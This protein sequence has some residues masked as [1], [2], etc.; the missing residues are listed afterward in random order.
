MRYELLASYKLY[1][2]SMSY[3][4]LCGSDRPGRLRKSITKVNYSDR[5]L[6][7]YYYYHGLYISAPEI[8]KAFTAVTKVTIAATRDKQIKASTIANS[9]LST[10]VSSWMNLRSIFSFLPIFPLKADVKKKCISK[11]RSSHKTN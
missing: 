8:N 5:F 4:E 9:A 3:L 1:E 10:P 7:S 6:A 11:T 2:V